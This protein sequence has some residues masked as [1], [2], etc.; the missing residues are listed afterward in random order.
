M[1]DSNNTGKVTIIVAII[2]LVGTISTAI[3][4]SKN[5][6][7]IKDSFVNSHPSSHERSDSNS[8]KREDTKTFANTPA[9]LQP[10][11]KMPCPSWYEGINCQTEMRQKFYGTYTG[12]AYEAGGGKFQATIALTPGTGSIQKIHVFWGIGSDGKPVSWDMLLSSP[13]SVKIPS[14]YINNNPVTQGTAYTDEGIGLIKDNKLTL[15]W[16]ANFPTAIYHWTL[17][18]TK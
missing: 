9:T 15:T 13:M 12:M 4:T 18:A 14:Q 1:S 10:N 17:T 3:I 16:T 2:G 11:K 5:P 8:G 6:D 7:K